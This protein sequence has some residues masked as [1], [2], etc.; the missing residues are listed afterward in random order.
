VL[1][2]PTTDYGYTS[3]GKDVTTNGY[4]SENPVPTTKCSSDGTC[5]YQFTHAIP[6]D[7][8]GTYAIGI[9][10]RRGYTILP[11]TEKALDTEYGA[12]NVVKYFSVDG[13]PVTP[14]RQVVDVAK[15]NGCHSNLS[16][17]GENRNQI[18]Q[19]VLCHN[20]SE[21]DAG[22]RASATVAADKNAPPQSVNFAL[23]IHKIHTGEKMQSEFNTQYTIVGFGGSHNDFSDV[24]Y[25]AMTPTGATGD[26]AK[27]DM[28]HVN[29]SEAA[30]PIGKN[31]VKDMQGNLNPAPA[32]TSAC[33]ACHQ[34]LSALAHAVSNTDPKF[35]ESCDVCHGSGADFDVQKLHAG[36]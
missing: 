27:C 7:A 26:T 2:G 29:N 31:P 11:G 9:E 32:T 19:C 22:R 14:R 3:F 5:A 12:K 8:T 15:C 28:C 18:E 34:K 13:T 20:A 10:A 33:T 30:L 16:L 21:T 35:G 6:A 17:H 36:K 4:V 23:M 1:A 25:P 24:R